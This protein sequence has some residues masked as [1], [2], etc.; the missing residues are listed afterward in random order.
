MPGKT[1]NSKYKFEMKTKIKQ[2]KTISTNFVSNNFD[3]GLQMTI[4]N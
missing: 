2:K 4:E 3:D 1:M